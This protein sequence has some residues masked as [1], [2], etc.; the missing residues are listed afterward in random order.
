MIVN[1]LI[2]TTLPPREAVIFTGRVHMA[3]LEY[4]DRN[5]VRKTWPKFQWGG[6]QFTFMGE[7]TVG[8][9][10]GTVIVPLQLQTDVPQK[11]VEDLMHYALL[12]GLQHLAAVT[13]EWPECVQDPAA[14]FD[15]YHSLGQ[16]AYEAYCA[17][18][19][20]KSLIS[21][22]QLPTWDGLKPEIKTAWE[23]AGKAAVEHAQAPT[24][25]RILHL[26]DAGHTEEAVHRALD[27]TALY[28]RTVLKEEGITL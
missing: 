16:T 10:P 7:G 1:I 18:S 28:I 14:S 20:G 15:I 24:F 21:G 12:N 2:H 19:G 17:S 3:G 13:K 11:D 4:M 26:I 6:N 5:H 23:A 27:I 22:A 8:P 25:R 9:K